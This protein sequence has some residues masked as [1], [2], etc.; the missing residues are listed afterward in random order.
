[1]LPRNQAIITWPDGDCR[2]RVYEDARTAQFFGQLE[3]ERS[4]LARVLVGPNRGAPNEPRRRTFRHS[5][6]CG[7]VTHGAASTHKRERR[8]REFQR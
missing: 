6:R 5:G 3:A 7:T 1:M 4:P 2:I 8:A